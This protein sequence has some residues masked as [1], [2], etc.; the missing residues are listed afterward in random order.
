MFPKPV[1]AAQTVYPHVVVM[2]SDLAGSR[3]NRRI[4]APM[5]PRTR[6][7]PPSSRVLPIV[8]LDDEDYVV[9][10]PALEGLAVRD[11]RIRSGTLSGYREAL[12]NAV[13]WLFFGI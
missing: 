2:Q 11:L 6:F 7:Q 4:V 8:T 3:G 5:V 10:V 9:I 1:A 13:D 12:L